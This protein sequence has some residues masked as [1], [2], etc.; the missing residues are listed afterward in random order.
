MA[1]ISEAASSGVSLQ[2]DRRAKVKLLLFFFL[3]FFFFF[4]FFSLF[5]HI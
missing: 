2:A 4:F 3:F 1:I 5:R